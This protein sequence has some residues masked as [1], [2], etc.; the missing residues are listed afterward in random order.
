MTNPDYIPLSSPF[1]GTEEL[2]NLSSCLAAQK[3]SGGGEY[4]RL[5]EIQL[6]DD[7]DAD[8][9]LL[10]TS[11]TAALELCAHLLNVGP[12]DEVILPSFTFVSTANAFVLR[13]A[14]P[15]FADVEPDTLNLDP[16]DVARKITPATKVI[17]VMH[18]AGVACD[19]MALNALAE[20]HGVHIIEDAAQGV[21]AKWQ[22]RYLGTIGTLGTFSF[23]DTKNFTS[24]EGGALVINQRDLEERAE[25]LREK[26][27]NRQQF[28]MGNVDKYTWMDVGSS[29]IPAELNAA[30]LYAQLQKVDRITALRK[31]AHELYDELLEPLCERGILERPVIPG[32]AESNYHLY[33]VR[34][35]DAALRDGLMTHLNAN[36]IGAAFHYIPLHT[37]PMAIDLGIGGDALPVTESAAAR[38]LRIPL[39][40]GIS[41]DQQRRVVSAMLDYV[42]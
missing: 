24:G 8:R 20:R 11:C 21:A 25:I 36:G 14:K 1:L 18:Y 29:Y 27:T 33:A 22:D 10:T 16:A 4:T 37:A 39:Y 28:I 35:G 3:L 41:E 12:G 5:C 2:D 13:G 40:A 15:V 23:H 26:G 6:Q 38:L 31:R 19:M 32:Y 30:V 34:L 42:K 7:Y 17:V 9:V